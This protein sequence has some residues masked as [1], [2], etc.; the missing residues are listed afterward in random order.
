MSALLTYEQAVRLVASRCGKIGGKSR[1]P[2]KVAAGRRNMQKAY[3]ARMARRSL[4]L[5]RVPARYQPDG[6]RT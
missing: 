3:A 6:T 2:A 5:L 4:R 1:S